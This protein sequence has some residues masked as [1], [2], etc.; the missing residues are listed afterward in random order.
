MK[1][2]KVLALAVAMSVTMVVSHQ[3]TP[4]AYAQNASDL[5]GVW[6]GAF[7]GEGQTPT[8]FQ[9]TLRQAGNSLSG[10]IV[11]T[12]NFGATGLPFLLSTISG[13][14]RGAAVSFTKTYD[15]TGGVRHSVSYS[16]TV[17]SGGRRVTGTWRAGTLSG[18][19]EL[20]R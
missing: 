9:A 7:W 3:A 10:S 5:S 19:F 8:N 6:Q 1:F 16:G 2:L 17:S 20:A 4:P 11:E 14:A 15:G 18:N 12:N 13:N